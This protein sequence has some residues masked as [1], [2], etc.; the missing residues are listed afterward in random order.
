M[1]FVF[2]RIATVTL[3]ANTTTITFDSIPQSYEHLRIQ[4]QIR[5]TQVATDINFGWRAN[6][7]SGASSY[8]YFGTQ[9]HAGSFY[10][11]RTTASNFASAGVVVGSSA[12]ANVFSGI[13]MDI[14]DYSSASKYKSFRVRAGHDR[15]GAGYHSFFSGAYKGSTSAITR[16]DFSR[17]IAG[18]T[19]DIAQ[20]SALTLYGMRSAV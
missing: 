14:T 1:P 20:Y 19:G 2:E 11:A 15:D 3:N 18:G 17:V 13:T 6:N 10:V 8:S 4:G 12:T 9:A 7:D 16:L 5:L